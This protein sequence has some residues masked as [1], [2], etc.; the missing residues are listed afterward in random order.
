MSLTLY[1]RQPSLEMKKITRARITISKNSDKNISIISTFQSV[2]FQYF[3]IYLDTYI[4]TYIFI[5]LSHEI[6]LTESMKS[7]IH[8]KYRRLQ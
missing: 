1:S 6:R 2:Q 8:E 5:H 3:V 7:D 4:F